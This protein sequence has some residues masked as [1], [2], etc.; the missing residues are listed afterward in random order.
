ML[1]NRFARLAAASVLA[2][3]GA[4]ATAVAIP[5]AAVAAPCGYYVS[6]GTGFM[7]NCSSGGKFANVVYYSGRWRCPWIQSGGT[8]SFGADSTISYTYFS[9]TRGNC[10]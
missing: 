1:K 6:G 8:Q 4:T 9:D 5:S 10:S 2:V 3:G 7:H